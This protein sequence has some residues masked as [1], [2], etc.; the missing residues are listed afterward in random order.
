MYLV[1]LCGNVII[2]LDNNANLQILQ[3]LL[4]YSMQKYEYLF[5]N[6]LK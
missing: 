1:V 6:N 3:K 5:F 2:Y 4:S